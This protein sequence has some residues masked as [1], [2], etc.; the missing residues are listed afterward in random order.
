M[1]KNS[2]FF[3]AEFTSWPSFPS[4]VTVWKEFFCTL[5]S[6]D[7]IIIPPQEEVDQKDFVVRHIPKSQVAAVEPEAV[8]H[9]KVRFDKFVQLVASHDFE[10]I[11]ARFGDQEIVIGSN[12]L[13]ELA[14]AHQSEDS[15]DQ[16]KLPV[17]FVVGLVL[18]IVVTYLLVAK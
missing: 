18:G 11:L 1:P 16:S 2:D 15:P 13:T 10:Q 6:M 5:F 7:D 3:G 4:Y 12:L 8:S 14:S 9:V 17:V